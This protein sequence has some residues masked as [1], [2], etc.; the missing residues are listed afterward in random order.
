MDPV[1]SAHC[2]VGEG[3]AF[4]LSR[5]VLGASGALNKQDKIG[6]E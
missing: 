2:E 3:C 6:D 4:C 1:L 5:Y